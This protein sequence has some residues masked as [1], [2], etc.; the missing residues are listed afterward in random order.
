MIKTA[1]NPGSGGGVNVKN[2]MPSFYHPEFE[3]SSILLPRDY[4]EINAWCRYF[5]KYDPLVSTAIDCHA[6]LPVSS[7]K[8]TLPK[9]NDR[10]KTVRIQRE[11]E[12]MMSMKSGVRSQERRHAL[13]SSTVDH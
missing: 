11:Y 3:P 12:E 7:I 9:S 1:N 4:R 10:A 6:E 5:Y 2:S 13:L 8:M